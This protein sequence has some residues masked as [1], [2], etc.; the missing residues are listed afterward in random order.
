MTPT[1]D[2]YWNITN[3][4]LM[5]VLLIPTLSIFAYGLYRH[6]R[7]WRIGIPEGRFDR[8]VQRMKGVLVYAFGQARVFSNY[9]ASIFHTFLFSGFAILFIGTL[10]VLVHEDINFRI[11]QGN[12]YL[13]FQSLTLDIFGLLSIFGVLVAIHHRYVLKPER[14]MSTWGDAI[15]LAFLLAILLTG[16]MVEGLRIVATGDPWAKWSPVG[17]AVGKLF[18]ALLSA[19]AFRPLHAFLWWFHL[20]MVFALI[21]WLPYSKLLHIF[22][23]VANIFFRSLEPK[24]AVV[25]SL[26][27]EVSNTFGVNEIGQFTWKDLLDLDACTECGRCQD[28]CPAFAAGKPLS[29]KSLILDLREHL[30]TY[31]PWLLAE[32]REESGNEPRLTGK[33]IAEDTL[34]SCTTCMACM[35]ECPVFIEHVP[36]IIDMRRYLVMEE[37]RFPE[38]MQQTLRNLEAR[39]HPYPGIS[40]SRTDWCQGLNL[41]ILSDTRQAD[42][43]YWVGCSTA[44]NARNQNTARAFSRLLQQAGVDFAI[45]G[46]EEHC[47]GDPARRIGNEYLFEMLARRNIKVL[48]AHKVKKIVTTCPHCFNTLKNEYPQF[49]ASFEVSHH[50]QLLCEL[51]G[52]GRLKPSGGLERK[53]SFH[54]PCYLGR[55]NDT[56]KEPREVISAVPRVQVVEM[57]QHRERGFCCGAGGGLMWMEEPSDQRINS[58]RATHALQTGSDTVSVACPFCM[59]MLEDGLKAKKSER[60]VSVLDIAELLAATN[61]A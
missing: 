56:Y 29:P 2:V 41:R 51:V 23:S 20:L 57:E 6:Y 43:L 34:W 30:Q 45:L 8:V 26:D 60:D 7:L 4:W 1:R 21:A 38:M 39:G 11:M 15:L 44:L 24:G 35:Q 50:S 27:M 28:A 47:S 59:I 54:D 17:L 40:A 52:Q 49:G 22:T 55:Y 33:A 3:I 5:Y 31:G 36:K 25:K 48:Q 12:F 46:E 32:K 58:R 61:N 19:N 9:H 42:Y 18:R 10:V 53:V 37:G 13:Y 14:L 16:F